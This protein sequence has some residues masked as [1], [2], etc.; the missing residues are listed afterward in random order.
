MTHSNEV[1]MVHAV[2]RYAG[3]QG[4]R[5][6]GWQLAADSATRGTGLRCTMVTPGFII[7]NRCSR[8]KRQKCPPFT[9]GDLFYR[10]LEKSRYS[11]FVIG[12]D[13]PITGIYGP[14]PF[15]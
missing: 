4:N 5:W 10:L 8:V 11:V 2:V 1:R 3:R 15:S 9:L 6:I 14:M 7:Q 13:P 12:D